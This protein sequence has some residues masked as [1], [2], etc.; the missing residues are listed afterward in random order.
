M[1][2]KARSYLSTA[3]D[4]M[5][6]KALRRD[7]V[8]WDEVRRT[9]FTEAGNAQRPGDT[10][11]AIEAALGRLG[12]GHSSFYDPRKATEL[13]GDEQIRNPVEGRALADRLGFLSLPGVQ[14]SEKV[15]QQYVR[16][17]RNAVA[18]ANRPNACGWVIDLRRNLGGNMWPMLAV[19]GPILGDGNVGS[20]VDADGKKT[21]WSIEKGSPRLDGDSTGWGTSPPVGGGSAPVAVLTSRSTGSSGEAVTVAFRGR[22]YT[23]SFG[24]DTSGVPTGNAQHRLPDGAILNLTEW[25]DAD[26]TG[27]AYDSPIPPDQPVVD[28]LGRGGSKD[29]VL[30]AA[31]QWLSEQPGCS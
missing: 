31:T 12:D 30:D 5:E 18:K 3:L 11:R 13:H 2:D 28:N 23:R 19:V 17:G 16:E 14:G 4:L 24:E 29:P 20:F 15:Y 7:D 21:V 25:K 22:P 10:Y 8:D 27:R 1:S 6:D 9:A 26:R